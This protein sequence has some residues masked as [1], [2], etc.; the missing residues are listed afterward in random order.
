MECCLKKTIGITTLLSL[1]FSMSAV[2]MGLGQLRVFSSLDEPFNAE[3]ELIDVGY[4]PLSGIKASLASVDE[5]Q[6]LGLE[7]SYALGSLNFTIE[8]KSNGKPIVTVRSHARMK[9]PLL[10]LL[11]DLTWAEGQ[12]DRAYTVLLDPP[13]YQIRSQKIYSGDVAKGND[14]YR[15][16]KNKPIAMIEQAHNSSAN[17]NSVDQIG[18]YGPTLA[19]ET[20]WQVAQRFKTDDL[21]LQQIILA[22]VGKNPSAFTEGNLNGLKQGMKLQIPSHLIAKQV[23]A[24]VVEM[25]IQAHDKAWQNRQPI[26]HV[27]LPPYFNVVSSDAT[28]NAISVI[29]PVPLVSAIEPAVPFSISYTNSLHSQEISA[30]EKDVVLAAMDTVRRANL[31]LIDEMKS[32]KQDNQHLKQKL[33]KR[34][35]ELRLVER[36][37]QRLLTNQLGP[38]RAPQDTRMRIQQVSAVFW[39]ILLSMLGIV[40]AIFYKSM[41]NKK[42]MVDSIQETG[43]SIGSLQDTELPQNSFPEEI[44]SPVLQP[45]KRPLKT[46]ERVVHDTQQPPQKI[47]E[48]AIVENMVN[49]MPVSNDLDVE[50][51][52]RISITEEALKKPTSE[53]N[54]LDF[55]LTPVLSED[56]DQSL[57][58]SPEIMSQTQETKD[59]MSINF[60]S[61]NIEN[62][63]SMDAVS[64]T[65]SKAALETLLSLAN[66]YISMGDEEAAVQSL[67][68]V[69]QYG[70]KKQQEAAQLLLQKL[71]KKSN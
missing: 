50:S 37:L 2:A 45:Q 52:P 55:D 70:S 68:E 46:D 3:I 8:K 35:R 13:H 14:N 9:D 58:G 16:A 60:E 31:I 67:E 32:L 41:R 62:K 1:S 53:S 15:I 65:K 20:V 33:A 5:F 28:G 26:Q 12:I 10:Q 61:I 25:E 23:P 39:L 47:D 7:R 19:N 44:I 59:E 57:T 43:P 27:L 17:S 30:S 49:D 64:P 51:T 40:G 22:I 66:T 24:D 54:L 48:V 29:P 56:K 21:L 34:E 42:L 18:F 4:I 69:I 38:G 6:Q 63:A 11:V 71:S 36:K